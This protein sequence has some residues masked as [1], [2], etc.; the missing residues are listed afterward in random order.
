[1]ARQI[2]VITSDD[3]SAMPQAKPV[4]DLNE[5]MR[6]VAATAK[7]HEK[8]TDS[9]NLLQEGFENLKKERDRKGENLR[10]L[11]GLQLV[12]YGGPA[13]KDLAQMKQLAMTA[14]FDDQEIR[15]AARSSGRLY[16]YYDKET[17]QPFIS[18][19]LPEGSHVMG[20]DDPVKTAGSP[21][22]EKKTEKWESDEGDDCEEIFPFPCS[23]D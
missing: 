2:T 6:K 21:D 20:A 19:D 22:T 3:I 4:K 7:K 23:F 15:D 16:G 10:G 18:P 8:D 5:R 1:M 17:R 13:L 12:L 14:F 11:K 9:Y